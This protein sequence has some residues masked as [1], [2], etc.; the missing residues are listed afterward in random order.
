MGGVYRCKISHAELFGRFFVDVVGEPMTV[1]EKK[2][3]EEILKEVQA[4]EEVPS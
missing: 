3:L 1:K 4:E 2:A